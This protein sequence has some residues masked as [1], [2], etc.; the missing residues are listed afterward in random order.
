MLGRQPQRLAQPQGIGIQ[1]PSIRRA[2]LSL[3][4]GQ[5]HIRVLF[6]QNIGKHLIGCRDTLAG[7]NHKQTNIGHFN[8]AFGQA[9]HPTLQAVIG[10][11]LQPGRVDDCK[12]QIRQTG[13]PFAQIACH[14]RLVIHQRQLASNQTVEQG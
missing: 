9:A 14:A 12:A 3:I 1:H 13:S 4:C 2:P 6:A 10:H 7:V 5:D 11:F 8:G